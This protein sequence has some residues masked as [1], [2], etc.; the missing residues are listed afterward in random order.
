MCLSFK[1][2]EGNRIVVVFPGW[3]HFYS[4]YIYISSFRICSVSQYETDREHVQLQRLT[5]KGEIHKYCAHRAVDPFVFSTVK[6]G[7]S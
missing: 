5:V 6:S 3:C 4:R 7:V 1:F 2:V